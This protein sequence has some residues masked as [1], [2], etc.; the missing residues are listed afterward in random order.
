MYVSYFERVANGAPLRVFDGHVNVYYGD[1]YITDDFSWYW[2][3]CWRCSD[4]ELIARDV[5]LAIML[6]LWFLREDE[7]FTQDVIADDDNYLDD[8]RNDG[9]PSIWIEM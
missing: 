3:S 9:D 6:F 4:E 1:Y 8:E 7:K 2:R 5:L